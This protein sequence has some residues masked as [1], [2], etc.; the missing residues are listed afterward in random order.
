M[1]V[2]SRYRVSFI[3]DYYNIVGM[4]LIYCIVLYCLGDIPRALARHTVSVIP[5][6]NVGG[7]LLRTLYTTLLPCN[8]IMI[9]A[10][11]RAVVTTKRQAHVLHCLA[12]SV[13]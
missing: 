7:L 5:S 1:V 6:L 8:V 9:N 13:V 2:I 12:V 3:T 11:C 10:V 4:I